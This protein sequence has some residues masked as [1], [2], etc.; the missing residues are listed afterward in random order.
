MN[1]H[2]E[3][4]R[5]DKFIR[6]SHFQ[7]MFDFLTW[8][9]E[10]REVREV[11]CF[12]I[13][14]TSTGGTI[15]LQFP[16]SKYT[17]LSKCLPQAAAVS[18]L[19]GAAGRSSEDDVLLRRLRFT[20]SWLLSFTC[21]FV[22]SFCLLVSRWPQTHMFSWIALS[23]YLLL[24]CLPFVRSRYGRLDVLNFRRRWPWKIWS[25]IWKSSH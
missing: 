14:T 7:Y 19:T 24:Y 22:F 10:D 1:K 2:N 18:P 21:E 3:L 23:L 4:F 5:F 9:G 15:S 8:L 17:C 12:R 13:R 16:V 11:E 25:L 20:L 6:N